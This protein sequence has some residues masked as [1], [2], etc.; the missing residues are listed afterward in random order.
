MQ[1]RARV[2]RTALGKMMKAHAAAP[3]P[4]LHA[5]QL[6]LLLEA[7]CDHH[8]FPAEKVAFLLG[9]RLLKPEDRAGLAISQVRRRLLK[10]HAADAGLC[11]HCGGLPCRHQPS[12]KGRLLLHESRPFE[13]SFI[14][15]RY[16]ATKW[17]VR[18]RP[19]PRYKA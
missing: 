13:Y 17:K 12:F 16:P 6:L 19:R 2:A 8:Q 1:A 3:V 4:R 15:R 10:G 18:G 9:E 5:S 11:R 14:V 7:W